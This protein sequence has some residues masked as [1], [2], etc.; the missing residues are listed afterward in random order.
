MKV[1]LDIMATFNQM[2]FSTF[3]A[4]DENITDNSNVDSQVDETFEG[5]DQSG[6]VSFFLFYIV[7]Y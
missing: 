1:K 6:I 4:E 5:L 3:H 7:L 2:L